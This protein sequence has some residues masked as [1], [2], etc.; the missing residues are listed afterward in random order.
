MLRITVLAIVICALLAG[1]VP[2][3]NADAWIRWKDQ[4]AKQYLEVVE[5]VTPVPSLEGY[6]WQF[7]SSFEAPGLLVDDSSTDYHVADFPQQLRVVGGGSGAWESGDQSI[8]IY[9]R[10][11]AKVKN[12]GTEDWYDFHFRTVSGCDVYNKYVTENTWS[13]AYWNYDGALGT[14]GWD[15]VVDP[16]SDPSWGSDYAPVHP[17]EY[18]SFET[19]IEVTDPSG[20][21]EV[22]FWPT[23]PEPSA[24]LGL[25]FGF[26]G[27][28]GHILRKRTSR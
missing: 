25:G 18:F 8:P 12:T 1:L 15:Y 21:F 14:Q 5:V 7:G 24:L 9:V 20:N 3:A 4:G 2:A 11:V 17:G 23:V 6:V 22:T 10:L 16:T 13:P 28:M 26:A 19:W 27:L